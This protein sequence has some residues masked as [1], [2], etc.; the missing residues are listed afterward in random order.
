VVVFG[1]TVVV[2][3]VLGASLGTVA[4]TTNATQKALGALAPAERDILVRYR[5]LE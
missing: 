1:W 2:W 4:D 3:G 5:S